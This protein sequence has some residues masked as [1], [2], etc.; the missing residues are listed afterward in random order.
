MSTRAILARVEL[1]G[2]ARTSGDQNQR[3]VFVFHWMGRWDQR[4][5]FPEHHFVVS[6][7][8]A[9]FAALVRAA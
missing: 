4:H 3:R 9:M 7:G 2:I 5:V 1:A 8:T 6:D